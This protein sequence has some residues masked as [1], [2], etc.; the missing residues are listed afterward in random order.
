MKPKS[1]FIGSDGFVHA[2]QCSNSVMLFGAC[3]FAEPIRFAVRLPVFMVQPRRPL[4]GGCVKEIEAQLRRKN[5][6]HEETA[7][8]G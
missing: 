8:R 7:T 5:G 2:E 4:C 3:H 1:G 6:T